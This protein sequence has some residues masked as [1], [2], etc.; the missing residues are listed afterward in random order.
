M[1]IGTTPTRAGNGVAFSS[2]ETKGPAVQR[3]IE[4]LIGR[5]V[6]DED[7]RR[8]FQRNPKGTLAAAAEWGLALSPLEVRALLATDHSL[9]DRVAD[10]LD[11]R[12]QKASLKN[13]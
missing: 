3:S 6:T 12:L 9:W 10:E 5:L 13:G 1:R 11:D 2:G 4:I 8:A 7:F